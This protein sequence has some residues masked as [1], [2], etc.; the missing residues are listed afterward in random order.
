MAAIAEAVAAWTPVRA[1]AAAA[2]AMSGP[3]RVPLPATVAPQGLRSPC[4]ARG[5]FTALRRA[6]SSLASGQLVAVASVEAAPATADDAAAPEAPSAFDIQS[7]L[8]ELCDETSIAE[9]KLK[10]GKFHMHVKR[11]LGQK[12]APPP[13]FYPPSPP[14][15]LEDLVAA[16]AAPP[17][18][19]PPPKQEASVDEG[20]LY[21]SSPTV[22]IVRRGRMYKGKRGRN[23]V[24]VG[25]T[26]KKG[27]VVCYIEQLSTPSAVESEVAGEV[28]EF[29]VDDGVAVG[30]GDSLIAV[31]P[32]FSGIK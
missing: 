18:P 16:G 19:P 5:S 10:V 3:T 24:E 21:V 7:L 11:N 25:S 22:G 28:V 17:A 15:M 31:R 13:V 23:L 9:V 29:L 2:A 4:V 8:L 14:T 27:Q 20:L 1:P 12:A 32:S 6:S 26:V 30:Y